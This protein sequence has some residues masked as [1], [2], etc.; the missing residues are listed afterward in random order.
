MAAPGRRAPHPTTIEDWTRSDV[1]HNSFLLPKDDTLEEALK[2]NKEQGLPDIGVSAAQG[3]LLNLLAK[4]IN[5]K[6]VLEVGTLGGYST[7]WFAKALPADGKIVTFEIDEGHAKI[8][9]QNLE[10]AGLAEKVSIV[11]GAA[12]QELPKLQPEEPFDL[13]FIDADKPSN[14]IYFQ[15][16]KRLLRKGGVIIVDN[17]VRNGRVSDPNVSNEDIE[18]VRALLKAIQSDEE[19]EA[20]TISTVGEKGYDGFLY[21]LRK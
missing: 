13:A 6:R 14:L 7:I 10:A 12:A 4:S 16:S 1:Y 9:S 21:A 3:K 15:E 18:G 5:A 20:T 17:V 8:A 11:V 2:N 19:I